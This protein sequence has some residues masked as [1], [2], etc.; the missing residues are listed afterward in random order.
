MNLKNV[1]LA[2]LLGV[3]TSSAFAQFTLVE[4]VKPN[5]ENTV[6]PYVKYKLD[7][8]DLTLIIHEDHSD[9][10][11]HV[12]VAY[13][14]GSA[15]ES[16]RNSG[17]AHFFEHMMFQGS[18]NVADEEHFK[19][20]S[21]AG[22]TNNAFT[23][24]DKTVYI[25][26]AP[27]NLTETLLWLEA[28]RMGTHL[29]GF[30]EEKFN[31][32]RDAVKNEKRQR[33][34]NQPY[35]M[36]SEVLFKS[37]YPNHPY[38]WT[39]IG[40]VDD[41]DDASFEDLRN[42]FLRWYG[43]NNATVVVSGDVKP[44]E[45][46]KWVSKYFSTIN[47]CPEVRNPRASDP[48]LPTDYYVPMTD[49][50][51]LP[52]V[53][54]AFPTVPAYHRDQ[55]ALDIM[56]RAIG[57]GNNSILYKNLVKTEEAVQASAGHNSLE[58]SGFM[59]FTAV[60][61]FGGL[62]HGELE[63][64]IRA[65]LEEFGK[66]GISDEELARIKTVF[67]SS[68]VDQANSV[69]SKALLLSEW[70]MMKGNGYNL[71]DELARYDEVTKEDVMRVFNKYIK[72]RKAVILNVSREA[73]KEGDDE[74]S[75]SVNPHAGQTKKTDPQYVGLEYNPPKDNF[76]RSVQPKAP[77]GKNI[78]VPDYYQTK[79]D[80]G[81]K[82]I[83][84]RSDESPKVYFYFEMAGGHL[85]EAD[86]KIKT[87]A[88]SMTAQMMDEGPKGM[89][90]EEFTAALETLGSRISYSSGESST[91]IFVQCFKDKMTE[92]MKLLESSLYNPRFDPAD[93]KRIKKQN[94]EGF[95]SRKSN[96]NWMA[97]SEYNKI[98]YAGT[99]LAEDVSGDAKSVGKMSVDDCIDF[100]NQF[101]S[102]NVTSVSVVGPVSQEEVMS[103]LTWI[104]TWKNKNVTVPA[105][106][107]AVMPAQ[108]T[109]IL[110]DKPYAPQSLVIAGYPSMKY[111]FNGDYYKS[112]IMN[113]SLGGAFSSRINLNL[114]EDKGY[115]YGARTGFSG[116][117]YYGEYGFSGNIKK[118]ATDSAIMELMKELEG[119]KKGGITDD[120]LS[121]TKSSILL[122]KALNYET[123]FQ[124]LGF[125]N[126]I[127][128]YNLPKDYTDQQAKI[129]Q[130]ITKDEINALATKYIKPENM[131]IVVV[132]H[133]YKIKPG[134]DK[135]GY[136]KVKVIEIN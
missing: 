29:D 26:T 119:F 132:G 60:G 77:A 88:A 58:L 104:K 97:A 49:N 69:Q 30:T 38:E 23:S 133:A 63:G 92:T 53:Q 18:K 121:F 19:I 50:I 9:P 52:L 130:N 4:E 55:A 45:V 7:S 109:V 15:R 33:Y 41:L 81:L 86:K 108:T 14:V 120:E 6:I 71:N 8:N 17:F 111:D 27:S 124:K 128:E 16:V 85:L 114:R 35:G 76:D 131:L 62:T 43:P 70:N 25:N 66:N 2:M 123:P 40:Y 91:T 78:I 134:L 73:P 106:P 42:F 107:Q 51:W 102:P 83:G 11:V 99:I 100:Y 67:K 80:N 21:E 87:G 122:S 79:F 112:T 5:K 64:R 103:S 24:F 48:I 93:F 32:Q 3:L 101:Y 117:S 74:K 116:N 57:G 89:T 126:G 90:S 13:H 34:D 105:V 113:F 136:G 37:L 12:Q 127:I 56:A 10:I 47:K 75:K 68:L 46:K 1:C 115:T 54:M 110:V 22:G 72:N 94:M 125:L 61:T 135:L 59:G 20:I 129:V 118:E 39:P 65:S 95:T 96:P 44:E 98:L 31:N 82:V 28:D 36:V 84:S